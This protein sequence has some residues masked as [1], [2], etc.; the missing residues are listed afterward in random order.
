MGLSNW[1][2]W[3]IMMIFQSRNDANQSVTAAQAKG[4]RWSAACMATQIAEV[5]GATQ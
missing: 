5:L 2:P 3:S 4:E 1:H